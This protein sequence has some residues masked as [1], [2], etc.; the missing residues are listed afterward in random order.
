M[1]T[2]DLTHGE[3]VLLEEVLS[4]TGSEELTMRCGWCWPPRLWEGS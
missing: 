2:S 1:H 3:Q 4:Q